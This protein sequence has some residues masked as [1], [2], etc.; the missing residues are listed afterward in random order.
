MPLNQKVWLNGT[1]D[2]LHMGHIRLFEYAKNYGG[3]TLRHKN[4]VCVGV[5]TDKRVKE[6][7]G[8]SRPINNLSHRIEF[9]ESIRFIDEVVI[10][11]SDDELMLRMI[12]F[13][14]DVMIIGGD[15]RGKKIIGDEF[16]K[17][18]EY[19]DRYGGLSSSKI[20]NGS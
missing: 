16:L 12:E 10:F 2:V 4:Y 14:P 11:G 17:K 3:A 8:E 6:L 1:F 15:Y 20:I 19:F 9:L 18:I 13:N 5:D 7:K